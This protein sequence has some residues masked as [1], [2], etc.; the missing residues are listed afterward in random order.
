[1][2]IASGDRPGQSIVPRMPTVPG[3]Y[4]LQLRA[5]YAGALGWVFGG[6]IWLFKIAVK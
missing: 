5:D 1:M 6:Q 4:I 3:T 2:V